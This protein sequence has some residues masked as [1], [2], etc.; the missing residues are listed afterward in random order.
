MPWYTKASLPAARYWA[1]GY[2]I[3]GIGYV[4]AGNSGSGAVR[5]NYAYNPASNTWASRA[6]LA[7]G[8]ARYA[9]TGFSILGI[10][11]I[12]GGNSGSAATS[13]VNAYDPVA[14]SWSTKASMPNARWAL[15]SFAISNIG[16][17]I[18]GISGSN[19]TLALNE[20]YNPSTNTWA[21]SASMP[22]AR[23][24][25]CAFVINNTGYAVGGLDAS[26][27]SLAVNE[28]YDPVTNTWS[29]KAPKPTAVAG[30]CAFV[31]SNRG[32][33][34][35]LTVNE[36]YDPNTN[37]WSTAESPPSSTARNY[38][39]AFA[40]SGV[41]YMAGGTD[42]S[43]V[44]GVVEAFVPSV[45][46][47]AA[48]QASGTSVFSLQ[49]QRGR[50]AATAFSSNSVF[51]LQVQRG[52]DVSVA[53][54]SQSACSA[55]LHRILDV[56]A[57]ADGWS[58][59][60]APIRGISA[61]AIQVAGSSAVF[62][63]PT[64]PVDVGAASIGSS[65][66][67]AF[68]QYSATLMP[69]FAAGSACLVDVSRARTMEPAI[70][71]GTAV[72]SPSLSVAFG[73]TGI[74]ASGRSEYTVQSQRGRAVTAS[75]KGATSAISGGQV[76]HRAQ[77]QAS[78]SS[79]FSTHLQ[80]IS[81]LWA[82]SRGSTTCSTGVRLACD[83]GALSAG[84]AVW[85]AYAQRA[86]TGR[87]EARAGSVCSAAL[88]RTVAIW[89]VVVLGTS[90][91]LLRPGGPV[92]ISAVSRGTSALAL[93][94]AGPV[95]VSVISR[96]TSTFLLSGAI[97]QLIAATI[98][99][100]TVVAAAG[101]LLGL[102]EGVY[103][104][105]PI[106]LD[107]LAGDIVIRF[108]TYA[109]EWETGGDLRTAFA[110]TPLADYAFDLLGTRPAPRGSTDESIRFVIVG[111]D[112]QDAWQQY[113]DMRSKLARIGRGR[114]WVRDALGN[115]YW[116]YVRPMRLATTTF[117]VENL[118]HFPV[119]LTFR[120]LSDWM[121]RSASSV[122]LS[123]DGIHIVHVSGNV[124]VKDLTIEIAANAA[125]GYASPTIE[126]YV[127]G[128]RVMVDR[129]ASTDR[130]RLRILT[131]RW[132]VLESSDGGTTWNDV[133]PALVVRSFQATVLHL[134]PTAN[135][136]FVSGCPGATVTISWYDTYA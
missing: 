52:R 54:V 104:G 121:A 19:V 61:I 132:V 123:G 76:A 34:V 79:V 89:P 53:F 96:G 24:R 118:R 110:E 26:G 103:P 80:N 83:A 49:A 120:R 20:A 42:G 131:K 44:L 31:L 124:P 8:A 12:A 6:Q 122:T 64:A 1:A 93:R 35:S 98:G 36:V 37:T 27:N 43:T 48:A 39:A 65:M 129:V 135:I 29:T 60:S 41:G 5:T 10:G 56:A 23:N 40:I 130:H 109:M 30:A 119:S 72:V 63:R 47:D 45:I 70:I 82:Q 85:A 18:G 21:P 134:E 77:A 102:E 113:M 94:L 16:Y 57:L 99:G 112:A 62:G 114:L 66:L 88:R 125:N 3:S 108:P 97:E 133:T 22:T 75:A 74:Q 127:T 84:G 100:D 117:G 13:T 115:R 46:Q 107:S 55:N 15:A 14:N 81:A 32:Y 2:D 7:A 25:L 71:T 33:V 4:V 38:A 92:E 111:Q 78:G 9:L 59:L 91:L 126:N 69:H 105:W 95:R 128:E 28:A 17:A 106:Y 116:A 73:V 67:S 11:Y 86:T 58:S 50:A 87:A 51:T 68:P 90:L 136:L 101:S